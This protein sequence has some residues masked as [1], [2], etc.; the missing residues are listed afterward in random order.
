MDLQNSSLD[1][2]V[3]GNDFLLIILHKANKDSGQL[4]TLST[5]CNLLQDIID[6]H[7]KG[8]ILGGGFNTFSI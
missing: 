7:C 2:K 5:P 6:I 4:N 3:S 1:V 8:T